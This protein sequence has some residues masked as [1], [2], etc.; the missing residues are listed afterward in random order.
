MTYKNT[1]SY[2]TW[3]H[4]HNETPY[5]HCLY[6]GQFIRSTIQGNIG[7]VFSQITWILLSRSKLSK[8]GAHG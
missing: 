2:K 6:W 5:W 1:G 3:R 8:T 4:V 7:T